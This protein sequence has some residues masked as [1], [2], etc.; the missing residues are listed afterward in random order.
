ML[1]SCYRSRLAGTVILMLFALL[2]GFAQSTAP[3]L[4]IEAKAVYSDSVVIVRWAP[5]NLATWKWG[6][7]EGYDLIRFTV[8]DQ[9]DTLN[10][11]QYDSSMVSLAAAL[12]PLPENEWDPLVDEN[13]LAGVAAGSIYGDSLDLLPPDGPNLLNIYYKGQE[14][15]NR[16]SF[17]LFA[18]DQDFT[19]AT[20]MGLAFVDYSTTPGSRYIYWVKPHDPDSLATVR[21]GFT[22]VQTDSLFVLP[23]PS[24]LRGTAGDHSAVLNWRR[25]DQYFT[26]YIL[27]RSDDGINF[28][29]RNERPLIS[30]A[31]P[32]TDDGAI[33]FVDSLYANGVT[34]IYRVRGRS[35]F[36]LL[37][38]PSDTVQVS[39]KPGPVFALL[40]IEDIGEI[41]EGELQVR[42]N[43][44]QDM[45]S[46][47]LGFDIYRGASPEGP[48]VK[49]NQTTLTVSE[50]SFIDTDPQAVNYYQVRN[51]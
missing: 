17:S 14:S 7:S 15:E 40:S 30:A 37:S 5:A 45:E 3:A 32:D 12:K 41:Q 25:N 34:F 49:L 9:G 6:N 43:F 4:Q 51:G 38:N 18:A 36:G 42:W 13:D 26:S 35:P 46:K 20:M 28:L 21:P 8:I 22:S 19:V 2:H 11:A 24:E 47:F 50:R 48:F 33:A 16:F 23:A 1:P 27:E 44:P 10:G 39:G 31:A 29:P